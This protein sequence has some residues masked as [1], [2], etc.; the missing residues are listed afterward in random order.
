MAQWTSKCRG[1]RRGVGSHQRESH[2]LREVAPDFSSSDPAGIAGWRLPRCLISRLSL[3]NP[4]DSSA[5]ENSILLGIA[6]RSSWTHSP[7]PTRADPLR[8]WGFIGDFQ[9]EENGFGVCLGWRFEPGDCA[10]FLLV[11]VNAEQEERR[12]IFQGCRLS[13]GWC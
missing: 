6:P 2:V 8:R 12:W 9:V 3:R 4:G 7:L 5:A 13:I 1:G 10:V 11:R